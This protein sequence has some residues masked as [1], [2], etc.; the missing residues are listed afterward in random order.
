MHWKKK[1]FDL[2]KWGL[3]G[4]LQKLFHACLTSQLQIMV[5]LTVVTT[6]TSVFNKW[7]GITGNVF[8]WGSY[9]CYLVWDFG[10]LE[11]LFYFRFP[12][13]PIQTP[14]VAIIS[15]LIVPDIFL[16]QLHLCN[17]AFK[18]PLTVRGFSQDYY[19]SCS[20]FF[21]SICSIRFRYFFLFWMSTSFMYIAQTILILDY[22][23]NNKKYNLKIYSIAIV[24]YA[25]DALLVLVLHVEGIF[26]FHLMISCTSKHLY[27]VTHLV[28]WC[29]CWGYPSLFP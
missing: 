9:L 18:L 25:K 13:F 7:T 21:L 17:C 10:K 16:Q 12:F 27:S 24:I 4:V 14:L 20:V 19:P 23:Y 15:C 6:E 8:G 28:L 1:A 11:I 29:D 5:P 26:S 3:N 2:R 22:H